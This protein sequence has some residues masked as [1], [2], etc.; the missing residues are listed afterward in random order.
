MS[1]E[2]RVKRRKEGEEMGERSGEDEKG[3][4]G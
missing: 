1:G 2:E 4:I 3:V